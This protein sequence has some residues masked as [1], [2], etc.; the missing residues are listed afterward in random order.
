MI[1]TVEWSDTLAPD[2]WSDTGVTQSILTDNGVQQSVK[3]A[4]PAAPGIPTR[5][6]RLKVSQP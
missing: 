5:F 6:A 4:V 3:A 1:F 2:S